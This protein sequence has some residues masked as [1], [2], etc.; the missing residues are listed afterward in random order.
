[1]AV[2]VIEKKATSC[3][4][5]IPA[6]HVSTK[7]A[8]GYRKFQKVIGFAGCV[9]LGERACGRKKRILSVF[10]VPIRGGQ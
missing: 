1:M 5:V 9:K 2:V 7:I 6:I 3:C 8:M 4:C 10:F